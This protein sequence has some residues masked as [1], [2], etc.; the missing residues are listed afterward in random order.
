MKKQGIYS[1][2]GLRGVAVL[3]PATGSVV[4]HLKPEQLELH[5]LGAAY[6]ATAAMAENTDDPP[7][8]ADMIGHKDS[9]GHEIVV[10]HI[11]ADGAGDFYRVG[12]DPVSA[13]LTLFDLDRNENTRL[14]EDFLE[15]QAQHSLVILTHAARGQAVIEFAV[16]SYEKEQRVRSTLKTA[17][18]MSEPIP[19]KTDEDR[20]CPSCSRPSYVVDDGVYA[21]PE[22]IEAIYNGL[23]ENHVRRIK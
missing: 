13:K 15:H 6:I 7:I 22:V 14:D 19:Y 23:D 20:P 3:E 5:L 17:A 9:N 8:I 2:A 4:E 11:V 21:C 10:G 1:F 18:E 12:H 16:E